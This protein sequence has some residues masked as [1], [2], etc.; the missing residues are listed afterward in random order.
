MRDYDLEPWWASL[1]VS[2]KERIAGKALS[3]AGEDLSLA[4]YP[5]CTIWWNCLPD[6]RKQRIHDHCVQ[7]HGDVLKEWND[8]DPYGD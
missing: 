3:R 4:K 8:A 6:I 7:R 1:P 5:S 2:E